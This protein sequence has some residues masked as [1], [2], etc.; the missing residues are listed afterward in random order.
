MTQREEREDGRPL[1]QWH[2]GWGLQV[3]RRDGVG[4]WVDWLGSGVQSEQH[5]DVRLC[6]ETRTQVHA[7]PDLQL[8]LVALG[9]MYDTLYDNLFLALVP[10]GACP[11]LTALRSNHETGETQPSHP[12]DPYFLEL[13]SRRRR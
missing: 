12:L 2:C 1:T 9:W 11:S 5:L 4:V 8:C 7:R 6:T 10:G 13:I 3:R